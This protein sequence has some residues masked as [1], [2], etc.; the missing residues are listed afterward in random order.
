[1]ITQY[2]STGE[3]RQIIYRH[4]GM[5]DQNFLLTGCAFRKGERPHGG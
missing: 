5:H 1:M 3:Y 2:M 4:V